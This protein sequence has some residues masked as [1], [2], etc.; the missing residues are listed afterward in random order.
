MVPVTTR[1]KLFI[2]ES[3][4]DRSDPSITPNSLLITTS[5]QIKP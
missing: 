2:I 1:I 5:T 4:G 3:Q